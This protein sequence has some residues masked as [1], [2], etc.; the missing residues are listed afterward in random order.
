[1]AR[2]LLWCTRLTIITALR[3]RG[4]WSNSSRRSESRKENARCPLYWWEI[5]KISGEEEVSAKRKPERRLASLPAR[6]MRLLLWPTE[7][8]KSC[9]SIWS[10]RSDSRKRP[11]KKARGLRVTMDSW[12]PC[13]S[14][15]ITV[16]EEAYPDGDGNP[17]V[18]WEIVL[19]QTRPLSFGQ[20]L[21]R[22]IVILEVACAL[23]V[24]T[25]ASIFARPEVWWEIVRLYYMGAVLGG[26]FWHASYR[27]KENRTYFLTLNRLIKF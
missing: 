9:F 11:G 14:C 21:R 18:S 13:V 27:G 4:K 19:V 5:K 10:S 20:I 7:M 8:F 26:S 16:G 23:G 25:V 24:L 1:M 2:D 22:T 15:L 6:I 3:W 12:A 17:E